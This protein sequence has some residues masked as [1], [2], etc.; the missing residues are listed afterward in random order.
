M[1]RAKCVWGHKRAVTHR[2]AGRFVQEVGVGRISRSSVDQRGR[3]VYMHSTE[4][5]PG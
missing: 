2:M 1:T 4:E 5:R 3:G